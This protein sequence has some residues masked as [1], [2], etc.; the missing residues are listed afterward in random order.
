MLDNP[1]NSKST[2]ASQR[3]GVP[4]GQEPASSITAIWRE[5]LSTY[6]AILS[7]RQTQHGGR[8]VCARGRSM[9]D[10]MYAPVVTRFLTYDVKLDAQCSARAQWHVEFDQSGGR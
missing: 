8:H 9:A 10:A 4:S 2:P 3:S 1:V 5:C 6:G 7:F